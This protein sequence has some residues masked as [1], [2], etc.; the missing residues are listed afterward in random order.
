MKKPD[1][2]KEEGGVALAWPMVEFD[3]FEQ[4]LPDEMLED[5]GQR[6]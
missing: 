6:P 3:A 1:Q 5:W 4:V 2:E